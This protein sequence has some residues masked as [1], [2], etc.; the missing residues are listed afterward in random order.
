MNKQNLSFLWNDIA[1]ELCYDPDYS[2]AFREVYSKSLAFLKIE[3]KPRQKLPFTDTGF[4]S[5]FIASSEIEAFGSPK[6][7]VIEWLNHEA[8]SKDWQDYIER[9][10]QLSLF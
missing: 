6:D 8:Q 7:Y 9:S 3:S 5:H 10:K 4:Q 2:K 1:I